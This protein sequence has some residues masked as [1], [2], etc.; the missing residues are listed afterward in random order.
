MNTCWKFS[1]F[2]AAAV[3][4]GV[5]SAAGAVASTTG[6]AKPLQ[7]ALRVNTVTGVQTP[8]GFPV[9]TGVPFADG[10]LTESDLAGLRVETASGQQIGRAS[11]RERV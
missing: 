8:A 3:V 11:C 10:Q 1:G 7:L 2:I 5:S 4:M 9:T 6:P